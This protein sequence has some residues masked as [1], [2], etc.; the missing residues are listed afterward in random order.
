MSRKTEHDKQYKFAQEQDLEA[1]THIRRILVHLA[2]SA[3]KLGQGANGETNAP[4]G[5]RQPTA[6]HCIINI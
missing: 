4:N 5:T 6:V 1:T 2:V 3:L